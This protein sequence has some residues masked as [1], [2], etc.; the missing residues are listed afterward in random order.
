MLFSQQMWN[1]ISW[2]SYN[3]LH[4]PV[5]S[6]RSQLFFEN[7][8]AKKSV[9]QSLF[10]SEAADSKHLTLLKRES[11]TSVF[12]SISEHFSE[13]LFYRTASGDGFWTVFWGHFFVIYLRA[14][15]TTNKIL[16]VFAEMET[17]FFCKSSI[18]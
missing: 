13:Q 6:K 9:C 7:S 16:L 2:H 12:M 3:C 17:L 10:F 11:D 4:Y 18:D 5:R 14:Q 8:I 15:S 1:L